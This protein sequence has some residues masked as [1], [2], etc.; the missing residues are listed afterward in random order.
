MTI[1]KAVIAAG[2]GIL[3]AA[4]AQ[5]QTTQHRPGSW[6]IRGTNGG[7][8]PTGELRSALKNASLSGAQITWNVNRAVAVTGSFSWAAS[9]DLAT[10]AA[11]KLDVFTSDVGVELC[12][13]QWGD[14]TGVTFSS[15]TVLGAG[16]RS[17]NHRKL[18]VDATHNLA[19]YAGAGAELGVGRLGMRLE[20]R[21][22]VS[23]FKPLTGA[24]KSQRRN[25][26]VI[27]AGIRYNRKQ[28]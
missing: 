18:D 11:P 27:M 7:F 6:E 13:K 16:A 2:A 4:T 10:A 26:V 1:S 17:Y 15:F 22:Y 24:G 25:D 3:L 14:P 8:V 12:P 5:A 28:S 19:G 9:K 23:G 21:D 20:V